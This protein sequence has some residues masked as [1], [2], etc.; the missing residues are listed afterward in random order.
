M[1][2][3]YKKDDIINKH[4]DN[5]IVNFINT[6]N[7]NKENIDKEYYTVDSRLNNQK[8]II[9]GIDYSNPIIYPKEYDPYFEYIYKKNLNSINT[10]IVQ[11]K[12]YI[13][14][15]S[16]NRIIKPSINISKYYKLTN[17]PLYFTDNSN[18][19]QISLNEADKYFEI[20]DKISL[21]GFKFYEIKYKN[22]NFFFT[23]QSNQVILDIDPNFSITIPYYNITI[24][25][26]GVNNNDLTYFK[27]IPL[28]V[29]NQ[30]QKI[31][32]TVINNDKKLTFN[33]PLTFYT[34]NV[35]D[36]VLISDCIIKYYY[37]GN[38]PI[39]Y[40]N[41]NYPLSIYNL[42]GYHIIT[43]VN[44]QHL[45]IKLK[46]TLS[47]NNLINLEG[48]WQNNTFITGG[49][50]IQIG[51]I[52]NIISGYPKSSN[53]TIQL[54][55][56][57]D[58]VSCIN[59]KSSEIPNTQK[60][61]NNIP[62]NNANNKLYWK[63]ALDMVSYSIEIPSGNYNT[64]ILKK[65]LEDLI[66]KVPRVINNSYIYKFNIINIDIN[67][68]AGIT[69]FKSYTKYI[70]PKCLYSVNENVSLSNSNSYIIRINHPNHNLNIG[71]TIYINGSQNFKNI[72]SYDINNEQ[73]ISNVISN[74]SY[75]I[76]INNI[77]TI[78][79]TINTTTQN[80]LLPTINY[81]NTH[82]IISTTDDGGN[83][84]TILTNNSFKLF[85]DKSDT[86][87]KQLGFLNVGTS[88]AIT[89]FT[90]ITNNYMITNLQ[91]Y[92]YNIESMQI[93][94]N[95]LTNSD[96]YNDI[97]LS[98]FRY[99]LLTCNNYNIC[100]NPN[101]TSY[102]YK[103]LLNGTPGTILYNSFVDN[104]IYFNPPIKNILEFNF[105]FLDSNGNEFNFYNI[106]NSFTLEI[107]SIANLP[108]NTNLSTS[109]A[110][111]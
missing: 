29:I 92:I 51:K 20:G 70:L 63:N 5:N 84:I 43:D 85:F 18:F 55:K 96:S 81:T 41:A 52:D 66:S 9:N 35:V 56:R 72:Y 48:V 8:N 33:L 4:V 58:N 88:I 64:L 100:S 89:D 75:E 38:Y 28:S 93:V 31:S 19:F 83:E 12:T 67:T 106:E 69:T 26:I 6:Q 71:D 99:I 76:T 90:N 79:N 97:N 39:N 73:I 94:N 50:T 11:N 54:D 74:D 42:I 78:I 101:G 49:N 1:N 111:L 32:L 104:P 87:G 53:Y 47:L 65:T 34:N 14:I 61:F 25:I 36:N 62:V 2:N 86:M 30:V 105:Q 16:A 17:N 44:N 60:V 108:E 21:E 7:E 95:S 24:E 109:I 98:G 82:N 59:M 91:P 45:T 107:T 110:R 103:I 23:N 37:L 40:I 10:Q 15:D 68:N 13:N 46:N 80:T 27:N 102:F 77:N 57:I 22:I 3:E